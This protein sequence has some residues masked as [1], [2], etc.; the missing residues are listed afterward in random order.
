M[1]RLLL[2]STLSRK[3][4]RIPQPNNPIERMV[5]SQPLAVAGD[6][7][8]KSA[9]AVAETRDELSM[10]NNPPNHAP[11]SSKSIVDVTDTALWVAALRAQE[12]ERSDAVFR[13]PLA[14]RL[15]G[16]RGAA[17]ARSISNAAVT[18]WGVVIRTSA[19]DRLIEDAIRSGIK[20]VVNLGA[21]LDMRPYRMKIP[22]H[23]H[24]VEI[25]FPN[26]I[27]L[28]DAELSGQTPTCH[29][30]RIGLNLLDGARRRKLF[31]R[32]GSP[33]TLMIAEGVVPYL[34]NDE[35]AGLADDLLA[36][37]KFWIL[38]FD[39]AGIRRTP[40]SWAKQLQAAPVLFQPID[41]FGF[42]ENCGRSFSHSDDF[43][44]RR[45]HP[46]PQLTPHEA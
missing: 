5:R 29:L 32:Y 23:I 45:P 10:I 31:A 39:D 27:Q 13:D 43:S 16:Q 24:W 4:T 42:F 15:A 37:A 1:K 33:S 11:P 3:V 38:D 20:C 8:Q 18:R 7:I 6:C 44:E 30:E 26:L 35:V 21:G 22:P 28:K 9:F 19:I 25:D 17:I 41:W 40:R 2:D 12:S 34:S 46:R 14:A 36:C